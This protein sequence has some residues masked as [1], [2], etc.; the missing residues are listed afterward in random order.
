MPN[1]T[2]MQS[3]LRALLL[4]SASLWFLASPL[5]AKTVWDGVYTTAQAQRGQTSYTQSCLRCHKADLMGIEGAMKGELFME[6]RREDTLDALFLD[7]K[8][9]MPR[10]NPGG[11]PDQTYADIISYIL[12]ANEMPPGS[13]ELTPD[14]V[15]KIDVVGKD[16][17]KPVPNFAPVLS[18][19]CLIQTGENRWMLNNASEPVRTRDSFN[20]IDKELKAS[21]TRPLGEYTFRLADA[22]N[23]DAA[24]NTGKKIQVKGILVRAEAGNRINVNSIEALSDS[25]R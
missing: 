5:H 3:S 20:H 4:F 23:F 10:G 1:T 2:G 6:R 11:L 12:Q 16:G 15:D 24:Q 8:A 21:Q 13:T 25:C 14:Q 7:M 22:E 17:P 18:V 9:T 19:G